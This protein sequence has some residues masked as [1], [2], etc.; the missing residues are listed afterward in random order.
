M[1]AVSPVKDHL[2]LIQLPSSL[3]VYVVLSPLQ[4]KSVGYSPLS[5][6]LCKLFIKLGITVEI[7][8]PDVQQERGRG[9]VH[10]ALK[11]DL[12]YF[13]S[14]SDRCKKK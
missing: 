7:A 11:I 12:A 3:L 10:T 13:Y 14:K 6:C 5:P 9:L 8:S 4:K 2:Q 1:H